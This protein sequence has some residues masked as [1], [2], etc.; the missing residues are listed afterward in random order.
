MKE[1]RFVLKN[2]HIKDAF[3]WELKNAGIKF[4]I[5]EELG[6]ESF[7]GHVIV[8]TFE[9]VKQKIESFSSEDDRKAMLSALKTFKE[10]FIKVMEELKESPKTFN[11]LLNKYGTLVGEVLEQLLDNNAI[12][13]KDGKIFPKDFDL[14]NLIIQFRIPLGAVRN[15]EELEKN[16]EQ[17]AYIDFMPQYVVEIKEFEINKA[18]RVLEIASK[19]FNL[20]EALEAYF[21]LLGKNIIAKEL[22]EKAK[23]KVTKDIAI[24]HFLENSPF[25]VKE[26]KRRI[27]IG[28]SHPK[29]VED[30]LREMEKR[31]QVLVKGNKIRL[32]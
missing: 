3:V 14:E 28:I 20:Y 32:P 25:E 10:G 5:R 18:N 27:I 31:G 22:L 11:E 15:F 30:I 6:F 29:A 16:A 24:K 19:Y 1:M 13:V 7:I 4:Q 12:E 21:A 26:E 2:E 23:E 9:E 8:G 17:F